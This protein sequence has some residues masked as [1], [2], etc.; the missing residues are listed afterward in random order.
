MTGGPGVAPP[1][2]VPP[3]PGM[4][5]VIPTAVPAAGV[6]GTRRGFTN[7]WLFTGIVVSVM[8]V[9]LALMILVIGANAGVQSLALGFVF[10]VIPLGIV[11][12]AFLWLDRFEPEPR[13]RL[14]FALGWGACVATVVSLVFN[15]TADAI[16]TRSGAGA[17]AAAVVS[18]PVVEE[19]TKGLVVLLILLFRRKD[20]DGIVDGVVL[21][22]ISAAGFAATENILYLASAANQTGTG[23]LVT[24]FVLRGLILPFTH[25][26]FTSFTGLGLGISVMARRRWVR[27]AAP[28]TGW[29]IAMGLH[30]LWNWSASSGLVIIVFP[31]I[32][33]PL[34]AAAVVGAVLMRRREGQVIG[35]YLWDY[36]R[37]GWFSPGEVWMLS[38]I[39]R[40][41]AARRWARASVGPAAVTAM[42]VF[43]NAASDLGLLR[44]RV[45]RG[46]AGA[47]AAADEMQ[48]L[49]TT[50]AARQT[51]APVPQVPGGPPR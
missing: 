42:R 36:V 48:L 24:V 47:D 22:G 5:P 49:A 27:T 17:G 37:S 4:V 34:F 50:A 19:T 18:A 29:V 2:G 31:V 45:V 35:R 6:A 28:I 1:P 21:A 44:F 40:R 25:P 39:S 15:T 3:Q 51:F 13:G 14:A 23:G 32:G 16:L 12:P 46:T 33:I 10:A 7:T 11:L 8:A 26:L 30:A 41:T 43:Q 20:F 9:G 38:S